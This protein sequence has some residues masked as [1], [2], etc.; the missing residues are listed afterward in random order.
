MKVKELMLDRFSLLLTNTSLTDAIRHITADTVGVVVDAGGSPL[1]IVTVADLS[2]AARAH[3]VSLNDPK[4][5]LPPAIVVGSGIEMSALAQSSM[6]QLSSLGANG[7]VVLGGPNS[8]VG[9]LSFD[10]IILR[11]FATPLT[12]SSVA[13]GALPGDPTT[14]QGVVW[15]RVCNY[16]NVINFINYNK[17][18]AC[19]NPAGPTHTLKV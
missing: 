11:T 14:P 3:A 8:V 19:T 6:L 1:S 13:A 10:T 17:M 4:A 12:M 18:P 5:E 7:A 2:R 9:V 15:C 16:P